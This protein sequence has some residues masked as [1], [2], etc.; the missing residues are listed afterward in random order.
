F[1]IIEK[2]LKRI[3]SI[4]LKFKNINTLI[5]QAHL[6]TLISLGDGQISDL[7][8]KYY[9]YGANLGSLRRAEKE[10]DLSIDDYLIKVKLGYKPW[11]I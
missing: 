4:K 11:I 5:K 7:L 8:I 3:P 9:E 6:Q 1:K 2:E 10:N